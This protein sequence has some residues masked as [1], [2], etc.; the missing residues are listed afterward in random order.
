MT[1]SK[2]TV[3]GTVTPTTTYSLLEE[4]SKIVITSHTVTPDAPV[5][6]FVVETVAEITETD[7]GTIACQ[8]TK[9]I[10]LQKTRLLKS[11]VESSAISDAQGGFEFAMESMQRSSR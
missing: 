11:T 1:G 5:K 8:V 3:V 4:N 10:W 6:G 2:S 7:E 9:V